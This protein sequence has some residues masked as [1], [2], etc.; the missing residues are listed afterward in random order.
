MR[1]SAGS[2]G[3]PGKTAKSRRAAHDASL[4]P[5]LRLKPGYGPACPE[6]Q[7]AGQ[8]AGC[9]LGP[10]VFR[11]HAA[12]LGPRSG[13]RAVA[14]VSAGPRRRPH[15]RFRLDAS[16]DRD[17][18]PGERVAHLSQAARRQAAGMQ[19]IIPLRSGPRSAK[20]SRRRRR[21]GSRPAEACAC[22]PAGT[23]RGQGLA[24]PCRSSQCRQH[25]VLRAANGWDSR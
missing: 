2:D 14:S 3:R 21:A 15:S 4:R 11:D 19:R 16:D 9:G 8:R 13:L 22:A 17:L 25:S 5:A 6:H 7:L 20:A 1:D 24:I 23:G 18:K 10:G 12:V